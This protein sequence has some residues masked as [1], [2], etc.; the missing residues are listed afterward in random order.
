MEKDFSLS[1]NFTAQ[2]A[3]RLYSTKLLLELRG[4]H[5]ARDRVLRYLGV[6][7]PPNEK[8]LHLEQQLTQ[9]QN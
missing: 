4:I 1:K 9:L 3:R 6:M 5:S 8:I 7:T 2:L